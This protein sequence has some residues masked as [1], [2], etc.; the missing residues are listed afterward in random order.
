MSPLFKCKKHLRRP[1]LARLVMIG[2][3][4]SAMGACSKDDEPS[5][6]GVATPLVETAS[7][8]AGANCEMGGV[9]ISVGSDDDGSGQL[10]AEEISNVEYVCGV[11]GA[12]GEPGDHGLHGNEGTP[13]QPGVGG[14]GENGDDG[15]DG[16]DGAPGPRG[17]PGVRGEPG[18]PGPQGQAG[19]QGGAGPAGKDGYHSLIEV[20]D[21]ELDS[22]CSTGWSQTVRVGLDRGEGAS[23]P[24]GVLDAAEVTSTI[25]L[26]VATVS[27]PEGTH[28]HDGEPHTACVTTFTF[29]STV[30]GLDGAVPSGINV[31]DAVH[32][33]VHFVPGDQATCDSEAARLTCQLPS[34]TYVLSYDGGYIQ[35]GTL[36]QMEV[37]R[38]EFADYLAFFNNGDT[39]YVLSDY[40]RTW[41]DEPPP[42]TSVGLLESLVG[43]SHFDF[44]FYDGSD[45]WLTSHDDAVAAGAAVVTRTP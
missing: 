39:V 27:C 38:G 17:E 11:Q 28:D 26:C 30:S 18:A 14:A 45:T 21:A 6:S 5:G 43:G 37:L 19:P 23:A 42:N 25:R 41:L 4:V 44:S 12:P 31:S 20:G 10:E 9:R 1:H 34:T 2:L 35:V 29:A 22:S 32:F 13:G 24:N 40:S 36:N 3:T 7:E 8:S 33:A 15:V 16:I